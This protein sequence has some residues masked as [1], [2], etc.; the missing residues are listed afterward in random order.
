M[1][2]LHRL[3]TITRRRPGFTLLAVLAAAAF[4]LAGLAIVPAAFPAVG[5][6]SADVLRSVVGVQ[7]VSQLESLSNGM[8]DR[9]NQYRFGHGTALPQINWSA[10]ASV[11]RPAGSQAAV[12]SSRAS[13]P[14]LL[15]PV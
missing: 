9:L 1:A 7:A 5:A 11:P 8:R 12:R 6:R 15:A 10:T 14:G 2:I 4:V 3:Y 13:K